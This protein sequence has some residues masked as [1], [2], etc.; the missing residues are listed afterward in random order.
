MRRAGLVW[1]PL[2]GVFAAAGQPDDWATRLLA[3]HLWAP[4]PTVVG[5]AAA[6][7]LWWPECPVERIELWGAKRKSP[8]PWLTTVQSTVDPDWIRWSGDIPVAAPALSAVLL[9]KELGGRAI[10]E[11]LRR[12]AAGLE[13]MNAALETIAN[14]EGNPELRRLLHLSRHEP[15]SELERAGHRLLD[16]A[17]ITGWKANHRVV[18]R[19]QEYFVDVAFPGPRIAIEF[20]GYEF[21]SAR[22]A[23]ELDRRRQNE[24]VLAGWTVLRFT[25]ATLPELLDTLR[26]ALRRA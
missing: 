21:H 5:A 25:W 20:D 17:G 1:S 24:L 4:E 22:E 11:A 3:A 15:W 14:H 19:G 13:A 9:A 6:K 16:G 12:R 26:R 23:F 10:D 7:L 8:A 2:P 18:L